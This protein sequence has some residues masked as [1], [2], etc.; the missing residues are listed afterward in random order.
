MKKI[1]DLN[2]GR[3]EPE[4]RERNKKTLEY[5]WEKPAEIQKQRIVYNDKNLKLHTYREI[6]GM[7]KEIYKI[8]KKYPEKIAVFGKKI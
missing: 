2:G 3:I 8:K 5:V 6:K 7:K 4:F 1:L